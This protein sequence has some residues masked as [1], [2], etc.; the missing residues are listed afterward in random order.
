MS[1]S[2]DAWV[3]VG[4]AVT[5]MSVVLVAFLGLRAKMA[6]TQ[7]SAKAA[8]ASADNASTSAQQAVTNTGPVSNGFA[9]DIL[10]RLAR[11][12]GRQSQ[13]G[14]ITGAFRASVLTEV[15]DMRL[16]VGSLEQQIIDHVLG[17]AHARASAS[18]P[19]KQTAA[20]AAPT[21]RAKTT[22]KQGDLA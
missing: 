4:I 21:R 22:V 5:Q 3:T 8:Q 15:T 20:K 10:A 18:A 13:D 6:E 12:E 17:G 19:T 1:L 11:I 14:E 9:A 7:S 16:K 2:H